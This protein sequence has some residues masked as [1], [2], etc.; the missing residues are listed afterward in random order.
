MNSTCENMCFENVHERHLQSMLALQMA[1]NRFCDVTLA[2]NGGQKTRVHGAVL[3]ANSGYF[4]S[5]LAGNTAGSVTLVIMKDYDIEDIQ[6][7]IQF[8]YHG[9]VVVDE[10]RISCLDF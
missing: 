3:C 9:I 2:C 8:M 10:V 6:L 4:D 5:V 7:L 1:E